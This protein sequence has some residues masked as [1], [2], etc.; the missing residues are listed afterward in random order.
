MALS[1]ARSAFGVQVM[2]L[3]VGLFDSLEIKAQRART[4]YLPRTTRGRVM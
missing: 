1:G 3:E 4:W 2:T